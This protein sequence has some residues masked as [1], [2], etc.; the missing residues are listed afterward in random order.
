MSGTSARTTDTNGL[1]TFDDRVRAWNQAL[2]V[3][4]VLQVSAGIATLLMRVPVALAALHQAGAL[5]VFIPMTGE[6]IIPNILGGGNFEFVGNVIG[7]QFNV[8][9][10][11]GLARRERTN[12]VTFRLRE[13]GQ[14]QAKDES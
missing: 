2:L 12:V 14:A 1:A 5:L 11:N 8:L 13:S 3:A 10:L 7:D 4:T 6:Y 9:A